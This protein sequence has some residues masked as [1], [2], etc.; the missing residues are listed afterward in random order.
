MAG[1]TTSPDLPRRRNRAVL[2]PH[3]HVTRRVYDVTGGGRWPNA[4]RSTRRG[5]GRAAINP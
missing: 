5:A 2:P 3:R 1:V 4:R